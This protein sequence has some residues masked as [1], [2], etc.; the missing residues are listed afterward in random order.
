MKQT[1]GV[2]STWIPQCHRCRHFIGKVDGNPV[3]AAFPVDIPREIYHNDVSH[4]QPYPG[5]NG[6]LFDADHPVP[7]VR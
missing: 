6:I 1:P 3:C 2:L 5:D 4:R 7:A